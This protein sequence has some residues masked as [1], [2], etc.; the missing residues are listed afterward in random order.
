M[1]VLLGC[2]EDGDGVLE[3]LIYRWIRFSSVQRDSKDASKQ[4]G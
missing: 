2:V 1:T 4:D 3:L